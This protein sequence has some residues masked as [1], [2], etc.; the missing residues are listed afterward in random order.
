[1][2]RSRSETLRVNERLKHLSSATTTF[3]AA[4][5]VGIVIRMQS[6]GVGAVDL[7]WIGAAATLIWIAS[8]VLTLLQADDEI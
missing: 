3:C 7:L 4:L 1:M 8:L 6:Q 5:S 2:N